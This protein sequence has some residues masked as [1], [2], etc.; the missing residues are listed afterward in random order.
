[1]GCFT[2]IKVM[3]IIFNLA[4]FVSAVQLL[5]V[6]GGVRAWQPP[7]AAP[8]SWAEGLGSAGAVPAQQPPLRRARGG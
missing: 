2:F 1:M 6:P 7:L 3:M 5:S 8:G 4:I